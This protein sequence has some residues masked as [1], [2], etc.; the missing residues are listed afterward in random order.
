MKISSDVHNFIKVFEGAYLEYFNNLNSKDYISPEMLGHVSLFLLSSNNFNKDCYQDIIIKYFKNLKNKLELYGIT[1][2]GLISGNGLDLFISE[3]FYKKTGGL[4]KFYLKFENEL[5]LKMKTSIMIDNM[6]NVN[7]YD[8]DLISGISGITYYYLKKDNHYD[9]DLTNMIIYLINLTKSKKFEG[10][11]LLNIHIKNDAEMSEFK[12]HG[13]INF[14]LSHG[15]MAIFLTLTMAYKKGYIVQGL[16]EAIDKLILIY[17]KF[18][19]VKDG[20]DLWPTQLNAINYSKNYW[21]V[22][23]DP[24]SPMSMSWCYGS[25]SITRSLFKIFKELN[26][27]TLCNYYKEKFVNLVNR[28][29]SQYMLQNSCLCHG[30]SS[31]ITEILCMYK[32]TLDFRLIKPVEK[33]ALNSINTHLES[34]KKLEYFL[35]NNCKDINHNIIEG[36]YKDLSLLEGVIGILL[37]L[38]AITTNELDYSKL[39]LID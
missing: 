25:M 23:E 4:K 28:P 24:R 7:P 10:L 37:S 6:E 12:K 16:K 35:S 5:Y 36:T 21:N 39:L 15:L 33:L 1:S 38:N 18:K 26:N 9:F 27:T 3:L 34:N 20:I 30:Y 22:D 17:D 19:I 14:S 31:V 13:Y 11:D 8:F 2:I 29:I 32:D